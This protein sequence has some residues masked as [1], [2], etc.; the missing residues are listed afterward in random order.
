MLKYKD[1]KANKFVADMAEGGYEA[2]HIVFADWRGPLVFASER[3]VAN[4]TDVKTHTDEENGV[5]VIRPKKN[6]G[7]PI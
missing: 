2:Q 3:H 4:L 5:F 1:A 7:D 6:C